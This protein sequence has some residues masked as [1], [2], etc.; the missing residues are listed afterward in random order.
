MDFRQIRDFV[1]VVRA[2]SF[3]AASRR[4]H[5]SQPGLGYQI[6]EL[7]RELGVELLTRHSR[8]VALTAA[9]AVLLEH[10]ENI[11]QSIQLAK[12]AVATL[13]EPHIGEISIGLS[14]TPAHVLGPKLM[15]L[16]NTEKGLKFHLH[17]ALSEELYERVAS[18][19]LDLAVCLESPIAE[20]RAIPLY[21]E[22]LYL[23]GPMNLAKPGEDSVPL[24]KLADYPL[25]VG[26]RTHAARIKLEAAAAAANV[27]L[28]VAQELEPGGLRRTLVMSGQHT[29]AAFGIFADDIENGRLQARRIVEPEIT[30]N[31][32]VICSAKLPANI[33]NLIVST[34]R[35]LV[36][37]TPMIGELS[38]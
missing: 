28:R 30:L 11:L 20:L 18:G 21:R 4:L 31:V 9:G 14:P 33:E 3:A 22:Y 29:V 19:T 27:V 38:A 7:E 26:P 13:C 37:T 15:E 6:K 5:I 32:N 35:S 1:A 34:V 10:A 17:E 16:A 8:G 25:V 23:I 24:A 36:S 2:G 12:A